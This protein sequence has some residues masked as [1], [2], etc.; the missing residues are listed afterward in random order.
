MHQVASGEAHRR[1][2]ELIPLKLAAE[3]WKHRQIVAISDVG[4]CRLDAVRLTNLP[5]DCLPHG[6]AELGAA[7]E[8]RKV[9]S[10]QRIARVTLPNNPNAQWELDAIVDGDQLSNGSLH[11]GNAVTE[12]APKILV[13]S[14]KRASDGEL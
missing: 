8:T 9:V 6:N 3:L 2:G 5:G 14:G 7:A 10:H 11:E 1:V 12:V 13:P 4:P